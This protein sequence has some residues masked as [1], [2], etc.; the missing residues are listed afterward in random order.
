MLYSI[1]DIGSNTVKCSVYKVENGEISNYD[2]YTKP[3]GLIAKIENGILPEYA[4]CQLTDTINEYISN[5]SSTVYCFA[6]ES[7]RKV[8]NLKEVTDRIK[9][10]CNLVPELIS[11]KDEALLSYEGFRLKAP[12]IKSGIMVDMGGGSTEILKFSDDKIEH[13]NSFKF[14]CLSLRRDHVRGRFP[15]E[16]EEN[17]IKSKVDEELKKFEWINDAQRL[18]LIGGTGTSIGKLAIELGYTELPEFTSETFMKL[19]NYLSEPDEER[20]SLLKKHIPARVETILPGMCAYRR[21]IETVNAKTVFISHGGIRDGYLYRK[22][23][24]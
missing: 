1:I 14:G 23:R 17:E 24:G 21:I 3:L 10:I 19:F 4:I 13:L 2:F 18:C 8:E 12:H 15:T 11:G 6:T 5:V 16:A 22:L 20:I 9:E 7:L